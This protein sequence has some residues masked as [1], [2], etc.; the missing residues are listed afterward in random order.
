[1]TARFAVVAVLVALLASLSPSVAQENKTMAQGEKVNSWCYWY[2]MNVKYNLVAAGG[3]VTAFI[4]PETSIGACSKDLYSGECKYI[5]GTL[6]QKAA[7]CAGESAGTLMWGPK[8]CVIV[9]RDVA[10]APLTYTID[11]SV[12]HDTNVILAGVGIICGGLAVLLSLCGGIAACC[13][14]FRSKGKYER[15]NVH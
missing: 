15:I 3:P 2:T 10:T 4:G 11:I 12:K 13:G 8:K 14:C 9:A 6:C 5:T 1:M 7:P